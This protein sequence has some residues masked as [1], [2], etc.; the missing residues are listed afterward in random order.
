[1]KI[2]N[3]GRDYAY[4]LSLTK[5]IKNAENKVQEPGGRTLEEVDSTPQTEAKEEGETQKETEET[6]RETQSS[7]SSTKK[8]K[9]KK[10]VQAETC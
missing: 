6:G 1:M 3:Y 2:Y 7:N 8:G 5:K 10:Q 9:A 4:E